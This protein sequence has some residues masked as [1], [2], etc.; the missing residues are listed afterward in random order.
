MIKKS[1]LPE[2]LKRA[3]PAWKKKKKINYEELNKVLP[4]EMNAPE[5]LDEILAFLGDNGIEIEEEGGNLTSQEQKQLEIELEQS[6]NDYM[7]L[8]DPIRMYLSEMGRMSLL[9]REDELRLAM[10][11]DVMRSY[12]RSKVLES[13]IAVK[14]SIKLLESIRDGDLAY[15]RTLKTDETF[16]FTKIETLRKLPRIID[17]LKQLYEQYTSKFN[18]LLL[19]NKL[20]SGA[21]EQMQKE[22]EQV[23]FDYVS[24]LENLNIQIKNIKPMIKK[25]HRIFTDISRVTEEIKNARK[26][27]AF[28][29]KLLHEELRKLSKDAGEAPE[30]MKERFKEIERRYKYYDRAKRK[31]SSGNLR[32][33][34]SIGKRYRNRGLSF[35]DIIQEGN[36]GLMKA[37]EKYE[38]RRGYKFSTYATW[39][40]RQAITRAIADNSRTVRIPVHMFEEMARLKNAQKDYVQKYGR[41]PSL[42]ELS[43][44]TDIPIEEAKRVLII[45]KHPVSLDKPV[46]DDD[47]TFYGEFIEDESF[48]KPID[49]ANRE[50]LK[51]RI[52]RALSTLTYREREILRLRYGIGIDQ[53]YTLEEVGNIFKVTRERVRQIEAKAISKLQH[54][55]RSKLLED[56]IEEHKLHKSHR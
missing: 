39:W 36:T 9:S 22:M 45:S 18:K 43:D 20:S 15:E 4:E 11:V 44:I 56:F 12:F 55:I 2:G 42:K 53:T 37:V 29:T 21:K 7:K 25:I 28:K 50:L 33:V 41:E 52:E 16:D 40:I 17:K 34:I 38:Y 19:D 49:T 51:E 30:A 31:L 3:L 35:L 13:P 47:E 6:K 46:G 23:R 5:K 48:D 27:D 14:E 24:E 32:L 26:E 54:P 10:L 8:I 1:E